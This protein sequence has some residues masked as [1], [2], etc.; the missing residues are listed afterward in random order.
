MA[1]APRQERRQYGS[2]PASPSASASAPRASQQTL[3]KHRCSSERNG[4]AND[5]EKATAQ[6]VAEVNGGARDLL[7]GK[8]EEREKSIDGRLGESVGGVHGEQVN[9]RRRKHVREQAK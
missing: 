8:A 6:V 9:R 3:A 2:P 4:R 5:Q 7:A 1:H